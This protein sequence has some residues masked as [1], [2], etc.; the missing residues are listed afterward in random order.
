MIEIKNDTQ[1]SI[2][3]NP[4]L[5]TYIVCFRIEDCYGKPKTLT[6][7]VDSDAMDKFLRTV[8]GVVISGPH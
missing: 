6:V 1:W 5:D 2:F 8:M 7:S 3:Y 4:E